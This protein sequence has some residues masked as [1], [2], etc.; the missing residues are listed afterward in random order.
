MI[1]IIIKDKYLI[2]DNNETLDDNLCKLLT[3]HY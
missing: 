3:Y 2:T 1:V